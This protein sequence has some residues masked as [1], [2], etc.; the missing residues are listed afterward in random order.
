MPD[1]DVPPTLPSGYVLC[2]DF[3]LRRIG[4]AIGQA[5]TRTASSLETLSSGQNTGQSPDWAAIEKLVKTWKPSQFLVG[6]P[7]DTEGNETDMSKLARQFG[8][9]LESRFARP[10]AYFDERFSSQAAAE[11]FVALR[12]SGQARRK[13]A[14]QLDSVAAQLILQNWLQSLPANP[15]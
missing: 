8:A 12:A 7:L 13:D 9:E 4:T 1:Q 3:G 10:C 11:G 5:T 6:L 14:K 15:G 2:F